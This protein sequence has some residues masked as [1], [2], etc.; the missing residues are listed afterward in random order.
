VNE[1]R[2]CEFFLVRYVPDPIRNEF[3]NI[4]VLLREAAR[5]ESTVV[6]FTR[7][8]ARVRCVDPDADTEMLEALESEM[9]R[10]LAETGSDLPP[11]MKTLEDS[12]SNLLQI[13]DSKGCLAETIPAEMEQLMRLYIEPHKLKATKRLNGRQAILRNMRM[14]FEHVGVWDL[15]QKRIA[16]S[17]YTRPGDP[18]KLDCGYR[19]NGVIRMFHAVSLDGDSELAKVLAFSAP[20]L[21]AGVKD[22][23]GADLEITAIVEPIATIQSD[24]DRAE[25]YE[26]GKYVMEAQ[27]IR[28]LTTE[29]LPFIAETAQRELRV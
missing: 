25:Q 22:R 16:A 1:R 28:V 11:M 26:F 24:A 27:K 3:V 4:G 13:T 2:Q 17:S 8:W 19:P 15:M 10:R 6:R 9:Q 23:E 14:Q 21:A 12:F 5:P 20:A 29:R 18:L 7:D